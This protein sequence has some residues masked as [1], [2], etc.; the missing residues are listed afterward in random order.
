MLNH[1]VA[2]YIGTAF[3]LFAVFAAIR[4]FPPVH[5]LQ[6]HTNLHAADTNEPI[7]ALGSTSRTSRPLEV[8]IQRP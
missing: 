3:A 7:A 1:T 2:Q 8:S 5:P 4:Q 6:R